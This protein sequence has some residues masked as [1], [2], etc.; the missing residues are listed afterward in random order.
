M[1]TMREHVIHVVE[2]YIDAVRR[3][4][5]SAVPLHPD[6]VSE[7]PTNTYYGAASFRQTLEQFASIMKGMDV[8][9]LVVDGEH[10]VALLNIDTVFGL[11]AFAKHIRVC[12]GE[13]VS[14]RGYCDPR[15]MLS[16]TKTST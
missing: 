2:K 16:G 7:F 14:I 8:I 11:I 12:N 5:A 4:D 1:E 10:T 13:I 9:Q 3:N 6:A 15:P